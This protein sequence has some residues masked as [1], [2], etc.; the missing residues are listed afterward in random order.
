MS[1]LATNLRSTEAKALL[2][3]LS[4]VAIILGVNI[5]FARGLGPDA[6][7]IYT[8]YMA[9]LL[10]FSMMQR[11]G[12]ALLLVRE[13]SIYL[14]SNRADLLSGVIRRSWQ[15]TVCG[16]IGL[17][18]FIIGFCEVLI[19][20]GSDVELRQIYYGLPLLVLL[21]ILTQIEAV[22]RGS[23]G[24]VIGLA[25]EFVVRHTAQL[26]LFLGVL[27]LPITN[28]ANP[29]GALLSTVAGVSCALLFALIFY[30]K[31][32]RR[33][34]VSEP[35]YADQKWLHSLSILTG[36]TGLAAVNGYMALLLAGIWLQ[37]ARIADLQIATQIGAI[38]VLG[39]SVI[40]MLQAAD[41]ARSFALRDQINIQRLATRSCRLSLAFGLVS[42][43]VFFGAGPF[44]IELLFGV[45]YEG[46]Y[47]L[48][49]ILIGGMLFN[50]A[51]GSAS[52]IL[53]SCNLERHVLA[54][55][56]FAT[57]SLAVLV[58][59]LTLK[60]GVVGAAWASSISLVAWKS[61]AV[62]LLFRDTGVVCLPFGGKLS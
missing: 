20:I 27:A 50:A 28:I 52:T 22:T 33:H 7:G 34:P 54:S 5:V 51:T 36:S 40:N 47:L 2:I 45:E 31:A 43:L 23:G 55:V 61:L 35:S 26:A 56:F 32:R 17:T 24:A 41:L 1:I 3:R 13:V 38:V 60:F 12:L 58:M 39:L 25:G 8:Y 14:S 42:A 44:V 62:W 11:S 49:L 30:R 18:A 57:I 6:F 59:P 19:W 46:A 10:M 16:T 21:G 15:F 4:S 48:A 29:T 53:N 37:P 9:W